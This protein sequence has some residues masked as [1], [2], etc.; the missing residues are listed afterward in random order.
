MKLV[1]CT[2][3]I[4]GRPVLDTPLEEAIQGLEIGG[5]IQIL[6]PSDYISARQRAWWKG[7]LLPALRKDTGE[8]VSVWETRLKLAVMPDEFQPTAVVVCGKPY[9]HVPSI[10]DL[11]VKKMNQ[12]IEGAVDYLRSIGFDWVTLPDS[13]LRK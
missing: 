9:L 4:G 6:S 11:S 12:L 7:I 5:A 1:K 8:S 3:I 10:K 2:A 13:E